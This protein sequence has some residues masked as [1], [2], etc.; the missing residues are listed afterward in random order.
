MG[1][2]K[3]GDRKMGERKVR[4][5]NVRIMGEKER[6]KGTEMGGKRKG[7]VREEGLRGEVVSASVSSLDECIAAQQY[8][9]RSP[10][11]FSRKHIITISTSISIYF[12]SLLYFTTHQFFGC[13]Q[14]KC[15][16]HLRR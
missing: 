12:D 4:D 8:M 15:I 5:R 1:D 6:G 11:A 14:L 2:R 3:M 16:I 13:Y 9:S 7:S 10:A